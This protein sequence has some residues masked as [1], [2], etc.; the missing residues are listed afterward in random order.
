MLPEKRFQVG[1]PA[2]DELEWLPQTLLS[3][4]NQTDTHFEV[5]ICVNHAEGSWHG[6][7]GARVA[8]ANGAT[9]A[10]LAKLKKSL[11]YPLHV[12]DATGIRSPS[13]EMAGVGWA[14]KSLFEHIFHERGT[15][16]IGISLDADTDL[17]SNYIQAL[18]E[19]FTEFP[20]C[21]GCAVPYYHRLPENRQQALQLLRYEIYLRYYHLNLWRIGSP[22]A[23]TALGSALAFRGDAYLKVRGF[24]ARQAGED[25]YLLQRLVKMGPVLPWLPTR[26]YP[27]SRCSQRVP[28]GTGILLEEGGLAVMDTRFPFYPLPIFDRIQQTIDMIPSWFEKP[29]VLPVQDFLDLRMGGV[30]PWLRMKRNARTSRDFLRAFHQRFD[31]L[32]LLQC[33]RFYQGALI[34]DPASLHPVQQLLQ[35]EGASLSMPPFEESQLLELDEIRHALIQFEANYQRLRR[36]ALKV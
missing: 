33:L 18:R 11:P 28:F 13:I 35:R 8:L 12:L 24:P 15:Q 20:N 9:L 25:F 7:A 31:G 3:L 4:A 6:S 29:Q 30:A 19:G 21:V 2:Y 34:P 1:I 27:A 36:G 16:I 22:Y 10:M 26:V 14:R 32:K 17:D 5:W 23:L